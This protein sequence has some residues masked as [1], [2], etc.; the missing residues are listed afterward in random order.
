MQDAPMTLIPPATPRGQAI[1]LVITAV[2]LT[3]IALSY[4]VAPG[5]SLPWL[6]GIDAGGVSTR[7]IFRAVMGL[8]LALICFWLAGALRPG[9]R[10]PA[11][12][13]LFVFMIGL[14]SG[15]IISLMLD[16]WPDPLLLVY[17]MLEVSFGL[18]GWWMLRPQAKIAH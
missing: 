4:G 18:L 1:F 2:G 11:L 9:L 8:Y 6:F 12:W 17:L 14:A 7:H 10:I 5:R 13:S 16:G 3:P 15:R